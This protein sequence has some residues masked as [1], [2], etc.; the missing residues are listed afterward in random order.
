MVCFGQGKRCAV[1]N[2]ELHLEG[3]IEMDESYIGGK[4]HWRYE[5]DES[6]VLLGNVTSKR[7][8]ETKETPAIGVIENKCH[9][10]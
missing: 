8:R 5:T 10:Y 7:G 4:P 1:I 9:L 6:I 3:M 2:N